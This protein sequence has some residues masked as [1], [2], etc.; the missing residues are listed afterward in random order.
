VE[1]RFLLSALAATVV[2]LLLHA[3]AYFLVLK[4]VFR[5]HPPLSEEFQRQLVRR[6][7]QMV[8]WAMVVT[9]L[10]MGFLIATTMRWAG[11]RTFASG[12]KKGAVFGLLFWASV[13]FGLYASSHYFSQTSVF[14]DFASSSTIMMLSSAVAAWVLGRGGVG[15]AT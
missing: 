14:V 11:A 9:A 4:S 15:R 1:R 5:S 10:A 6:P 7:D 8:G 3:T 2:N 13:N 12:L